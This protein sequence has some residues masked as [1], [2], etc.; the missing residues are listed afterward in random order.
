MPVPA[1]SARPAWGLVTAAGAAGAVMAIGVVAIVGWWRPT[2]QRQVVEATS[3]RATAPKPVA[4][5]DTPVAELVQRTAPSVAQVKVN[6]DDGPRV[7]SGVVLGPAGYLVTSAALV[8]RQ[9]T[10]RVT[11]SDGTS[12]DGRVVSTDAVTALAVLQVDST[13]LRA[14]D[15]ARTTPRVGDPAVAVSGPT[16]PARTGLVTAGIVSGRSRAV[17]VGSGELHDMVETDHPVPEESDGGALVNGDGAV[18]GVCIRPG[19]QASPSAVA[20][21]WAVP[22]DVATKVVTDIAMTGHAHHVWLGAEVTDAPVSGSPN[23]SGGSAG[24]DAGAGPVVQSVSPSSPAAD[25]GL[26]TGD[27][28]TAVDRQAVTSKSGLISLLRRHQPGDRVT[29]AYSHDGAAHSSD[30]VLQDRPPT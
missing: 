23:R 3:S 28:V 29:V 24:A 20:A 16:D 13:T 30:V 12:L 15:V 25:A 26:R 8:G 1:T 27:V 14:P 2:V 21:G 4:L 22:I 7:G 9:A 17:R 19:D 11:F 10:V 6:L 5:Y 18:V